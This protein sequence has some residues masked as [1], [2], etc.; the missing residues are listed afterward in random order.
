MAM[1][2]VKETVKY[3]RSIEEEKGKAFRFTM[4]TNGVLLNQENIDYIN[5]EMSNCVLS[6]DGRPE[7]NDAHRPTAKGTGSYDLIVP[8]FQ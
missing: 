7:V 4:T 3:A 8:K 1:E 5:E 2:T 6:L